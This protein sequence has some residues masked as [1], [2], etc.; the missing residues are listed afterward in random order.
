MNISYAKECKAGIFLSL[1]LSF[2]LMVYAPL[3]MYFYNLDDFWLSFSMALLVCLVLFFAL[4]VAGS[5]IFMFLGIINK[6]I[7]S[8]GIIGAFVALICIYIQG[9]FLINHLSPMDG[10]DID[11]ELY[12]SENI[13][14]IILWIVVL[15]GCLILIKFVKT[16]FFIKI[17]GKS[18]LFLFMILL[19][20][21]VFFRINNIRI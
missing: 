15:A 19:F 11:W 12:N 4:W 7:Y 17:A 5:L 20:S 2:L 21:I 8:I 1:C 14:T 16:A 6:R 18:S 9:T 3:E 13:M 10:T